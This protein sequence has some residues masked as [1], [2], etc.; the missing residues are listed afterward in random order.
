MKLLIQEELTLTRTALR[1]EDFDEYYEL[2]RKH[3]EGILPRYGVHYRLTR[4]SREFTCRILVQKVTLDEYA[5]NHL[6]AEVIEDFNYR[7]WYAYLGG[8]GCDFALC[9]ANPSQTDP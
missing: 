1:D 5:I 3:I 2:Y 6:F 7:M 9:I 4:H 8:A